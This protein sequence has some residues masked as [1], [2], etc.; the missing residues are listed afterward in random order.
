VVLLDEEFN[1]IEIHEAD[2][3]AVTEALQRPGSKARNER[4]Q[5]GVSTFK[6]AGR[7]VWPQ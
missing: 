7:R 6:A 3:D 4:G 5:L 1:A 2:R